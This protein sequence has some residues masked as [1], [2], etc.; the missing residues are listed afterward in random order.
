[1]VIALV[2]SGM[3]SY[4]DLTEAWRGKNKDKFTPLQSK[5]KG[6]ESMACLDL[7]FLRK[8]KSKA[9]EWTTLKEDSNDR[10]KIK[11][12]NFKGN[13]TIGLVTTFVPTSFRL[14]TLHDETVSTKNYVHNWDYHTGRNAEEGDDDKITVEQLFSS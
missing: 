8:Q 11:K 3:M 7:L 14:W 5:R 10:K 4:L 9:H 12:G 2:K 1:M 13:E 6:F